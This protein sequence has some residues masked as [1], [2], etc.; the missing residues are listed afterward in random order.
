MAFAEQ[1]RVV[2]RR[3]VFARYF[4]LLHEFLLGLKR[5]IWQLDAGAIAAVYARDSSDNSNRLFSS[6][7]DCTHLSPIHEEQ[8][9][10]SEDEPNFILIARKTP[11]F[12]AGMDSATYSKNMC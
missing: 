6:D 5:Q 1:R 3:A 2:A 9:F 8:Q 11:F 7:L 12:R 10:V 4:D